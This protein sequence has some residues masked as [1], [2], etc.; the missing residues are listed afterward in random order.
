MIG[1]KPIPAPPAGRSLA[2][3]CLVLLVF[4]GSVAAYEPDEVRAIL[5]AR[6][7]PPPASADRIVLAW[8]RELEMLELGGFGCRD[9]IL[10]IKGPA[11]PRDGGRTR[12]TFRPEVERFLMDGGWIHRAAG[13]IEAIP[14][15]SVRVVPCAA[16]GAGGYPHLKDFVICAPPLAEGDVVE[17]IVEGKAQALF[18]ATQYIGEHMF[19]GA[20]STIE[21]ELRLRFP[22]GLYPIIWP[23]GGVPEEEK[24]LTE[25]KIE[26]RWLLGHLS[27]AKPAARTISS[28]MTGWIPDS[29]GSPC[30]RF[31][32]QTDWARVV[33]ARRRIW[34]SFFEA[35]PQE[36]ITA[37]EGLVSKYPDPAE[38]AGAA[39]DWVRGRLR[40]I[41]IPAARLWFEPADP[42]AVLDC[43]YA[44]A[45]DRAALTVWL[46]RRSGIP[47]DATLVSSK[48]KFIQELVFPQQLDTWA[49]R[50]VPRPGQE[51][52]VDCSNLNAPGPSI[53][54]GTA[55]VWTAAET[56]TVLVPFP[57][58][59][60]ETAGDR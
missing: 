16:A 59:L 4:S 1:W 60:G 37:A 43:G 6:P 50:L 10:W 34:T 55:L 5:R 20:D 45:R 42:Q 44:I 19:A 3:A 46:A 8:Q 36:L 35:S 53:P 22:A 31:A 41:A 38:R 21:S 11:E 25:G 47:A 51:T 30:L 56:D 32:F 23:T 17:I 48:G 33:A 13:P 28:S 2:A 57:G 26:A 52:W 29:L 9:H 39:V 14:R 54:A 27:P 18:R 40:P 12:W 58:I 24:F 49:V 15:D 7:D